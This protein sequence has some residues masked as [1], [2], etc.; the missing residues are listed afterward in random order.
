MRQLL[1]LA[2]LAP[3]ALSG[4]VS[5]TAYAPVINAWNQPEAKKGDYRVKAGDT[6]Y[7]IAW[8]FG[9]DYRALAAANHLRAPYR[10]HPGQR[11]KMIT[12][13][14]SVK[15][16]ATMP[17]ASSTPRIVKIYN[18]KKSPLVSNTTTSSVSGWRWPARGKVVEGFSKSMVGNKGINIAGKAGEPV[19]AVA[20]GEVVYS[21]S[22][23]RGYGN[24]IIIKHNANYLSAYAYNKRLLVTLGS[25][26]TAGQQIAEMG[27]DNAGQA[28]LHFEIR[29]NGKPVNP[30]RY[31]P[32]RSFS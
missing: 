20:A 29:R 5:N 25:R 3:F 31:L 6:L 19:R 15:K 7:S 9:L 22:G 12:S 16:V 26:V 13:S 23:V 11:L 1:W 18:S 32:L 21:G 2:L 4:C 8:S 10:L 17:S 14:E 24:L 30:L 28:L 27:R